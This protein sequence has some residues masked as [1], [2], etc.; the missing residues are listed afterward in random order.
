M[1]DKMK[2][3]EALLAADLSDAEWT[4]SDFSGGTAQ[5]CL[6]ITRVEGLGYVLRHSIL[7]DHII[8]LTDSEYLRYCQGVQAG[9]PK[10]VADGL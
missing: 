1:T 7:T 3:L 9:Q 5:D 2:V 4:K 10:L 6:E 8:P